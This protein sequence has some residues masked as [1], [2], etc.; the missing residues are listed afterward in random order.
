MLEILGSNYQTTDKG[1]HIAPKV[2]T[3]IKRLVLQKSYQRNYFCPR[4]NEIIKARW[5]SHSSR[6]YHLN[7]L[8][9]FLYEATLKMVV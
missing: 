4:A 5:S 8:T 6:H 1:Q 7:Y 3:K 2:D 9:P